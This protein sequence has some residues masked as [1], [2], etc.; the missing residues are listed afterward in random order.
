MNGLVRIKI[1]HFETFLFLFPAPLS[2]PSLT[3]RIELFFTWFS[4]YRPREDICQTNVKH[5][6][7]WFRSQPPRVP[8]LRTRSSGPLSV[9]PGSCH[10]LRSMNN[11]FK[12]FQGNYQKLRIST[13]HVPSDQLFF[14]A[15]SEALV[16]I[17]VYKYIL[18][19]PTF[20]DLFQCSQYIYFH[21]L[22]G[23]THSVFDVQ[24]RTRQYFCMHAQMSG[25][26]FKVQVWGQFDKASRGP[27]FIL[28]DNFIIR[29]INWA[30]VKVSCFI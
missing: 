26:F 29:P 16:F 9:H 15:L 18:A 4:F 21:L 27:F 10:L 6:F 23:L 2:P 3:T 13:S 28:F 12:T 25:W 30:T 24:N 7:I 17:V 22:Q 11:L 1:G 8:V 14:L 5:F 20:S 19:T